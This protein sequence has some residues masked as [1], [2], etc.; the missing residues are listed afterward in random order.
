M[1][2]YDL[3]VRKGLEM[4][5]PSAWL[6][7]FR[8]DVYSQTGEDGVIEKIL[9]LLP[10][11]NMWCVEFGAW[12]G[13]FLTNTRYLI[14]SKNYSAILIEG[15]E[16]R[17][18]DLQKNYLKHTNV[19]TLNCYVGFGTEDNLDS[20]LKNTNIPHDFD[21]LS[22]DID[23]NDYHVWDA[24]SEYRPKVV[25]IEF[26]PT[27]SDQVEF[28]QESNPDISQGASLSSIVNLAKSK[29]YEL[30]CV[31]P[32][33]AFFV[34]REY[35]GCFNIEDNSSENLRTFYDAVTHLFSGY[36]GHVFIVGSKK[37]HWH[38]MEMNEDCFQQL[39]KYLQCYPSKYT[40]NQKKLFETLKSLREKRNSKG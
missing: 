32:W 4:R 37:L 12:D 9:D 10:E 24:M 15:D 31:L 7:D 11:R 1:L 38:N 40:S 28:V 27:I 2:K 3:C 8:R 21:L 16:S 20:L 23:G 34:K 29:G 19:S 35:F 5:N 33:N 22:I 26:N 6:L 13:L 25:V 39:P 14:E 36:D 30:V 18:L 17:F